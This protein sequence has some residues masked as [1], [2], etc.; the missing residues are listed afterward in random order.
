M[1]RLT[2]TFDVENDL[3]E[4]NLRNIL[5]GLGAKY[6]KTLP[7]SEHLKEDSHFKSLLKSKRQAENNLYKYIDSKR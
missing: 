6:L 7:D 5:E 3:S 2:A 1:K 4:H